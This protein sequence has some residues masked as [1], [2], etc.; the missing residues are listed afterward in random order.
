MAVPAVAAC[1]L[2]VAVSAGWTPLVARSW[3]FERALTRWE[4]L[5]EEIRAAPAA[6]PVGFFKS[7]FLTSL[8]LSAVAAALLAGAV[9]DRQRRNADLVENLLAMRKGHIVMQV[10]APGMGTRSRVFADARG[11]SIRNANLQDLVALAF[12]A[13]RSAVYV[14]QMVSSTE[15]D[16][17]DFWLLSPRYDIR[18]DAPVRE[19]ARFEAYALHPLITRMLAE[20]YGVEI[21][22]NGDC[23]APCGRHGIRMGQ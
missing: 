20:R 2:L 21:H 16:P 22:V 12:A 13:N 3:R 15:S 18:I 23:Q 14:N 9:H 10:A 19:P 7:A 4:L 11:V 8:V 5:E 6:R 1:V 17:R